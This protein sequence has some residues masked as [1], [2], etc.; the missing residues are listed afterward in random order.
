[1]ARYTPFTAEQSRVFVDTEQSLKAL[2]H[3]ERLAR[4]YQGGMHWKTIKGRQYL[5]R[6]TDRLGNAASLGARSEQTERTYSEFTDGKR[7]A[8][9]RLRSLRSHVAERARFCIA[10]RINRVPRLVA[11]ILQFFDEAGLL[12]KNLMVVGTNALY[13]YE[14]AGACLIGSDLLATA[15]VDLLWDARARL[16]IARLDDEIRGP[17]FLAMLQRVDK[18]FV[19]L[20]ENGFRALNASGFFVDLIKPTPAPALRREI[21]RMS[22]DDPIQASEIDSLRWIVSS[23]KFRHTVIGEDGFPL[24]ISVPDPRAFAAH[25]LWLSGQQNREPAKKRRDALQALV[26]A[27]IIRDRLPHYPFS[28][29]SLKSFPLPVARDVLP[30][31]REGDSSEDAGTAP[32]TG[33]AGPR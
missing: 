30:T 18:S 5:Y 32:E 26:V 33:F 2:D 28:M 17:G 1:M 24:M 14:A 22:P 12:G 23:E 10:A 27:S 16:Q 15:D 13:A 7:L 8:G 11:D 20:Q 31:L 6:T 9:E 25:K 29:E 19:A 21:S 4:S 3:A